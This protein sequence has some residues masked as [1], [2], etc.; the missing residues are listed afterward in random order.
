MD[1]A[2]SH[3]KNRT[4]THN[5]SEKESIPFI[6]NK[7]ARKPAYYFLLVGSQTTI[8]SNPQSKTITSI[9]IGPK[10]LGTDY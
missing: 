4:L 3:I 1:K 8:P 5:L 10:W 9:T 6:Y 7:Q 2:R